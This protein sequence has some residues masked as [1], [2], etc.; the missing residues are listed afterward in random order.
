MYK[1]RLAG[2]GRQSGSEVDGGKRKMEKIE[3]KAANPYG[4]EG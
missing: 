1:G 3:Q 2:T 4:K